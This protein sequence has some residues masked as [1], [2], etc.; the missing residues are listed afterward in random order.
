V[1]VT[2]GLGNVRTQGAWTQSGDAYSTSGAGPEL[3]IEVK[4]GVGDLT[5]VN[6]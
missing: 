2:G 3:T 1:T 5:L 6:K 4:M